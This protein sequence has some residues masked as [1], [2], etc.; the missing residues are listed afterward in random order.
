MTHSSA[1]YIAVDDYD[2]SRTAFHKQLCGAT[3]I[4]PD[5]LSDFL[6][7]PHSPSFS[8]SSCLTPPFSLSP[9]LG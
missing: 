2:N 9:S 7:S 3:F 6:Y 1:T 4:I 8:F 5:L